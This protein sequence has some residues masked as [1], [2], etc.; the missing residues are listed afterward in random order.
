MA[1]IQGMDIRLSPLCSAATPIALVVKK[2]AGQA[3]RDG[4]SFAKRIGVDR[5]GTNPVAVSY[6]L[7]SHA[8]AHAR[9]RQ[10]LQ[11]PEKR[12]RGDL[13]G[14]SRHERL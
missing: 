12:P 10:P 2:W 8:H 11:P 1:V 5:I 3:A 7:S 6:R 13:G 9:R 14:M 4:A